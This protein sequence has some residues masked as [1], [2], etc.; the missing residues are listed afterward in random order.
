MWGPGRSDTM[1]YGQ[2]HS[3]NMDSSGTGNR[4]PMGEQTGEDWWNAQMVEETQ[5]S[6]WYDGCAQWT[7]NIRQ[8]HPP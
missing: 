5:S 6:A 2:A 4:Q 1:R 8:E 3:K 7:P